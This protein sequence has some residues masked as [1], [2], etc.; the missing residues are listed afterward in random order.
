[1]GSMWGPFWA[2]GRHRDP[3][4]TLPGRPQDAPKT[5]Q[6]A[7]KA[8]PRRPRSEKSERKGAPFTFLLLFHSFFNIILQICESL[9]ETCEG[10]T[11]RLQAKCNTSECEPTKTSICWQANASKRI[12]PSECKQANVNNVTASKRM[13]TG[14]CIQ[15]N[16]SC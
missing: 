7:P 2:L 1:M 8:P 13:Q 16:A 10:D 6:D 4:K 3:P 11:P 5:P 15:A 14:D 12:Q 9:A